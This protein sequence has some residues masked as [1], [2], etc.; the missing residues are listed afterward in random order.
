MSFWR[1]C[2]NGL[3][4]LE[5]ALLVILLTGLIFLSVGQIVLRNFFSTSWLWVDPLLRVMVL[6]L[7]LLGALAAIRAGKP[8]AIDLL[9]KLLPAVWQAVVV[10]LGQLFAAVVSSMIAY[11]G[12]G[13]LM[14]EYEDA[15]LGVLDMPMWVLQSIIPITFFCLSLRFLIQAGIGCSQ[16]RLSP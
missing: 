12:V 1:R 7:G 14:L 4:R 3:H 11:H 6:W 15:S 16:I 2:I 8:I 9:T 10:I 13:F 5:D